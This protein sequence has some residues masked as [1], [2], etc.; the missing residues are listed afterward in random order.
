MD[1]DYLIDRL[2][3]LVQTG[4]R[5]PLSNK[6]MLDE[7]ECYTLIDQMRAV[8]PEEIKAAKRTLNDR[9]RILDEADDTARQIIEQAEQERRMMIEQEGLLVEAERQRD[10][11]LSEATQEAYE[12]R[13]H[14]QTLYDEGV[15]QTQEMREGA[16]QYAM[17]VLQELDTLLDKHLTV[18]R[19]GLQNFVQQSQNYQQQIDDYQRQYRPQY[20]PSKAELAAQALQ[21]TRAQTPPTRS[22]PVAPEPTPEPERPV[23]RPTPVR[24]NAPRPATRNNQSPVEPPTVERVPERLA[25]RAAERNAERPTERTNG[26]PPPSNRPAQPTAP[27]RPAN[28]SSRPSPQPSNNS[29]GDNR[30]T[31]RLNNLSPLR[32]VP[33]VSGPSNEPDSDDLDEV[34]DPDYDFDEPRASSK[35]GPTNNGLT[36]RKMPSDANN[37]PARPPF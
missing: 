1:I 13:N 24:T 29:N 7:Q 11:I 14:A 32:A 19:N 4:K 26:T 10:I 37:R 17:Q 28:S 27:S 18:V 33:K 8:V 2:E 35:P 20:A 12:L 25:D 36:Q 16:N 22:R 6:V 34:A 23:T 21:T 5:V 9:E 3:A 31:G 30:L 15:G